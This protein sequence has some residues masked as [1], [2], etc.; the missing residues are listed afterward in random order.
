MT[1]L[2]IIVRKRSVALVAGDIETLKQI[3]HEAFVYIDASGNRL[4]RTSYL[5]NYV[6]SNE[7]EWILQEFEEIS[8][9]EY[10]DTAIAACLVHDKLLID[11]VEFESR[12]RATFFYIRQNDTWRCVFGQSTRIIS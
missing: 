9:R 5:E 10:G 11:G 4:D 6:V 7:V 1:D 2:E 3:L 8:I 12:L